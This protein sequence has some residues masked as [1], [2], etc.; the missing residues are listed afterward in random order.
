MQTIGDTLAKVMVEKKAVD[1]KASKGNVQHTLL[2]T[3]NRNK[4]LMQALADRLAVVNFET[5]EDQRD[6]AKAV[7]LVNTC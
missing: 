3:A 6:N 1:L 5:L 2:N 7:V 4:H